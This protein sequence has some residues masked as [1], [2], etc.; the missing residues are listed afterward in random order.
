MTT[1]ECLGAKHGDCLIL[2]HGAVRVLFDGGP[3][4]VYN[5]FLK[6]WIANNKPAGGPLNFDLGMVTHIDDDHINGLLAL[7]NDMVRKLDDG[8]AQDVGFTQFW[9]NSFSGLTGQDFHS[10]SVAAVVASASD[11]GFNPEDAKFSDSRTGAIIASVGQGH[12]LSNNL[13]KLGLGRNGAFDGLIQGR[14]LVKFADDLIFD[15]VG[16]P[17]ERLRNLR[18]EWDEKI[19][20]GTIANYTD[21]TVPN[22]SSIVILVEAAG[23]KLLMTGDARG[24][25]VISALEDAGHKTDGSMVLD[26]L[27]LPHHGSERNVEPGFFKALPAKIYVVSADGKFD[28]PDPPTIQWIAEARGEEPFEL[29]FASPMNTAAKQKELDKQLKALKKNR[30]FTWR[31]RA[32]NDLS[33]KVEL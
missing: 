27:K 4:G 26:V 14:K 11:P 19:P 6:K 32:E 12:K 8:N 9:F 24:D 7:T 3:A 25:D 17:A 23:K 1:L 15:V 18:K 10:A 28:N 13:G 16:P 5:Q 2:H 31:F 21:N 29:V 22:L 20:V 30:N 33:I